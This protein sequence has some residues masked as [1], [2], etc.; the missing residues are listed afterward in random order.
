MHTLIAALTLTAGTVLQPVSTPPASRGS[1]LTPP[2]PELTDDEPLNFQDASLIPDWA[3]KPADRNAAIAYLTARASLPKP[4]EDA[5]MAVEWD[6]APKK[7]GDPS[8]DTLDAA[9]KALREGGQPSLDLCLAAAD[10]TKCDFELAYEGG[11][12]MLMPHLSMTRMLARTLRLDARAHLLANRPDLAAMSLRAMFRMSS[13]VA[14][15]RILISTLVSVAI[16]SLAAEEAAVLL[17]SGTLTPFD[18]AL[19]RDAIAAVN[20][21]GFRAKDALTMERDL[22]LHWFKLAMNKGDDAALAAATM[23]APPEDKDLARRVRAL[24]GEALD[25]ELARAREAY[26]EVLAAWGTPD[27]QAK[28]AVI[29]ERLHKGDFGVIARISMPAFAKAWTSVEKVTKTLKDLDQRLSE[30]K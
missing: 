18:A 12:S 13:H 2:A 25:R 16:T 21:G 27:T 15:D 9:V 1:A 23:L 8:H 24:Q 17:D 3:T 30:I 26:D 7:A 19:L 28:L 4:A 6:K 11:V 14:S 20:T 5:L 10:M 22:F 29:G